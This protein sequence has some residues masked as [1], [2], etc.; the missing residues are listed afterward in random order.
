[1]MPSNMQRVFAF[2]E[3]G[4]RTVVLAVTKWGVFYRTYTTRRSSA[5]LHFECIPLNFGHLSETNKSSPMIKLNISSEIRA[6]DYRSQSDTLYIYT[7]NATYLLSRVSTNRGA[8]TSKAVELIQLTD[9]FLYTSTIY[10]REPGE[11]PWQIRN[12]Q[13]LR[14]SKSQWFLD[15]SEQVSAEGAEVY[16]RCYWLEGS[17]VMKRYENRYS[18]YGVKGCTVFVVSSPERVSAINYRKSG[19]DQKRRV[20]AFMSGDILTVIQETDKNTI[21]FFRVLVKVSLERATEPLLLDFT[22]ASFSKFQSSIV[23]GT[24]DQAFV[25]GDSLLFVGRSEASATACILPYDMG[26]LTGQRRVYEVVNMFKD[27]SLGISNSECKHYTLRKTLYDEPCRHPPGLIYYVFKEGR[28][29]VLGGSRRKHKVFDF[30]KDEGKLINGQAE[31]IS[32]TLLTYRENGKPFMKAAKSQKS[33]SLGGKEVRFVAPYQGRFMRRGGFNLTSIFKI[34]KDYNDEGEENVKKD[35][36]ETTTPVAVARTSTLVAVGMFGEAEHARVSESVF[37]CPPLLQSPFFLP[38]IL[39]LLLV[40]LLLT[41]LL[42]IVVLVHRTYIIPARRRQRIRRGLARA[43]K[44]R[45]MRERAR[46]RLARLR[47]PTEQSSSEGGDELVTAAAGRGGRTTTKSE[48]RGAYGGE[49]G[50]SPA[51]QPLDANASGAVGMA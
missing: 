21:S 17:N 27:S 49:N 35:D 24:F 30:W 2:S 34:I 48:K 32:C 18:F 46:R 10:E 1:M 44:R 4:D 12:R 13:V 51:G 3:Y 26:E 41:I 22:D 38:L 23:G 16:F 36:R 11:L 28:R 39:K 14:P 37:E 40:D 31:A 9:S 6:A 45:T 43:H 25:K 42:I 47:H 33:T 29:Q 7:A 8:L 20:K 19:C 50:G 5:K 15:E